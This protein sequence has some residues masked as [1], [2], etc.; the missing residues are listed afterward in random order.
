MTG[1]TPRNKQHKF[2]EPNFYGP[3]REDKNVTVADTQETFGMG[4]IREEFWGKSTSKEF[5]QGVK[6]LVNWDID[7]TGSLVKRTGAVEDPLFGPI[8]FKRIV[9][10]SGTTNEAL[11]I[12]SA[13]VSYGVGSYV[14]EL[15]VKDFKYEEAGKLFVLAVTW[16]STRKFYHRLR[17]VGMPVGNPVLPNDD[18]FPYAYISPSR[19]DILIYVGLKQDLDGLRTLAEAATN[20]PSFFLSLVDGTGSGLASKRSFFDRLIPYDLPGS[21][22]S[23]ASLNSRDKRITYLGQDIALNIAFFKGGGEEVSV[24]PLTVNFLG[25][26]F[27]IICSP[28]DYPMGISEDSGTVAIGSL[29][30]PYSVVENN[31][32]R[33]NTN[34]NLQD[35]IY[36]ECGFPPEQ[37]I[38]EKE[39]RRVGPGYFTGVQ[40]KYSFDTTDAITALTKLKIKLEGNSNTITPAILNT[41]LNSVEAWRKPRMAYGKRI[42]ASTST[43]ADNAPVE[44]AIDLASGT[45]EVEVTLNSDVSLAE[46]RYPNMKG[47]RVEKSD[48][49]SGF[50]F[51]EGQRN[52]LY[53]NIAANAAYVPVWMSETTL[54]KCIFSETGNG[55]IGNILVYMEVKSQANPPVVTRQVML[56]AVM[57]YDGLLAAGSITSGRVFQYPNAFLIFYRLNP[58]TTGLYNFGINSLFYG[59]DG[60]LFF[61]NDT[62]MKNTLLGIIKFT[63]VAFPGYSLGEG[64]PSSARTFDGRTILSGFGN[65]KILMSSPVRPLGLSSKVPEPLQ[66]NSSDVALVRSGD[67]NK[68]EKPASDATADRQFYYNVQLDRDRSPIVLLL[69][70]G[71]NNEVYWTEDV[72]GMV[73]GTKR[74]ESRLLTA[75]GSGLTPNISNI[76]TAFQSA[77]G[78]GSFRVAK[79]DYSLFFIGQDR[80]ELFYFW[81]DDGVAGLRS[82]NANRIG[83]D[84]A[85][86]ADIRWDYRRKALWVIH[87]QGEIALFYLSREYGIMGWSHYEFETENPQGETV[88]KYQAVSLFHNPDNSVGFT[89]TSGHRVTLPYSKG[90]GYGSFTDGSDPVT[91]RVEFFR[92]PP[93]SRSGP[94][95][96]WQKRAGLC[97]VYT[98]NF[99]ELYKGGRVAGSTMV[100][101]VRDATPLGVYSYSLQGHD[102][103]V[104][105]NR[106]LLYVAV[107]HRKN[108]RAEI[109]SVSGRYEIQEQ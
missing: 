69:Q 30:M 71:H 86:I 64:F 2:R 109:L 93:S 59:G 25:R 89:T 62:Q 53:G 31:R 57:R 37:Y 26:G 10:T 63:V 45:F 36:Y 78:S 14:Q 6:R 79:G 9:S 107:E 55:G 101:D 42:T 83:G 95:T 96:I 75:Q 72:R 28:T 91:S 20:P 16:K 70:L 50:F 44:S 19:Y 105:R 58:D 39:I 13:D 15:S 80:D 3:G 46:P 94:S 29:G 68:I 66:F 61:T 103:S 92:N 24:Q 22:E 5:Q 67:L 35:A 1:I 84:L 106:K 52:F 87:G 11:G 98:R 33:V 38:D 48:S 8:L 27:S 56:C 65:N 51:E 43:D 23:Q 97:E 108:E 90:E 4:E 100:R 34:R 99:T 73:L 21:L 88:Q 54:K 41:A 18:D 17:P 12:T 49:A 32:G 74:E 102:V 85:E 81:Y 104:L 76:T 40:F 47:Y 82:L 60:A 7:Q 77:R